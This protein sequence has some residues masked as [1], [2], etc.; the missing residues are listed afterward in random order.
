[1]SCRVL[2]RRVEF[3]VLQEVITQ[4]KKLGVKKL[5]GTYIP[6]DR[7]MIVKDHYKKLGFKKVPSDG[8]I[9]V[10]DLDVSK[11]KFQALPIK[12]K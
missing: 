9:D 10:W 8:V 4:A 6:T 3:A 12:Y 1:M 2:G 5:V 7:N 11:Y